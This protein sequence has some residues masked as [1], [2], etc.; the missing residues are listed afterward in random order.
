MLSVNQRNEI[1]WE[2][3]Q[4]FKKENEFNLCE[5]FLKYACWGGWKADHGM[6]YAQY[7]HEK[8]IIMKSALK[9]LFVTTYQ[10]LI[11]TKKM[12]RRIFSWGM[13]IWDDEWKKKKIA[14]IVNNFYSLF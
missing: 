7:S 5:Y 12:L 10:R 4:F 8:G 2:S 9:M 11:K 1:N 13:A 14:F 3:V 6:I